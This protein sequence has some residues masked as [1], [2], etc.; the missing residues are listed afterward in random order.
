MIIHVSNTY[1]Q[2]IQYLR[3]YSFALFL[4]CLNMK[5]CTLTKD[6]GRHYWTL[7]L[8][9]LFFILMEKYSAVSIIMYAREKLDCSESYN[10]KIIEINDHTCIFCFNFL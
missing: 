7:W 1:V 4:K 3:M 9:E 10:V 2:P 8:N 6:A 5:C